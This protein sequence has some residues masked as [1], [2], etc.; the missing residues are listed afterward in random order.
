MGKSFLMNLLCGK[1]GEEGPFKV[2][3]SAQS[4][5]QEINYV[6]TNLFGKDSNLVALLIDTPGMFDT[7]DKDRTD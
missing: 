3:D 2:G 4:C 7:S 6:K 5:T 1:D